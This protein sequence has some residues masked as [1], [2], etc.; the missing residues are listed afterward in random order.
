MGYEA[1]EHVGCSTMN[2]MRR[3]QRRITYEDNHAVDGDGGEIKW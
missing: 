3:G 2:G 1:F